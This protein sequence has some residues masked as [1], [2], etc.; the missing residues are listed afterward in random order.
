[1][2]EKE[3]KR[4]TFLLAAYSLQSFFT[5]FTVFIHI[6]AKTEVS[7]LTINIYF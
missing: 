5:A 4:S 1:M 7:I 6:W 3:K 2:H